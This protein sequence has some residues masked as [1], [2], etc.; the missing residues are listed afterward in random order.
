MLPPIAPSWLTNTFMVATNNLANQILVRERE[1]ERKRGLAALGSWQRAEVTHIYYTHT[2]LHTDIQTHTNGKAQKHTY[3]HMYH[4][5]M[6]VY[7]NRLW[8]TNTHRHMGWH[9]RVVTASLLWQ[10][11]AGLKAPRQW[12]CYWSEK[13]RQTMSPPSTLPFSKPLFTS[14]FYSPTSFS[15][16]TPVCQL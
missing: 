7:I 16:I 11:V 9:R 14:F 1:R 12:W 3:V 4:T 10:G 2:N 13:K 15:S 8:H 5:D 6:C